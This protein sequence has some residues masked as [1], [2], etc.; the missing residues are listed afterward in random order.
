[1]LWGPLGP[2]Q[3]NC[4]RIRQNIMAP[5]LYMG[6]LS[7]F[8]G[9]HFGRFGQ[10]KSVYGFVDHT[11]IDLFLFGNYDIEFEAWNLY[12]HFM[13]LTLSHHANSMFVQRLLGFWTSKELKDF[14]G[15]K[16]SIK[17][18]IQ[19]RISLIHLT[20]TNNKMKPNLHYL[21]FDHAPGPPDSPVCIWPN[22]WLGFW[23]LGVIYDR[24]NGII[25]NLLCVSLVLH[26][27][28]KSPR[29]TLCELL[30]I[31]AIKH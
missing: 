31:M 11:T 5:S 21:I 3:I 7:L 24:S 26:N 29:K 20:E 27:K 15:T 19:N 8:Q 4:Q 22:V 25:Y 6:V 30:S 18:F 23:R 9:I 14:C 1:M 17:L 28:L 13:K 16:N 2:G 10:L 12:S